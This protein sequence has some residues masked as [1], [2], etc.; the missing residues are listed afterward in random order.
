MR[1]DRCLHDVAQ[2]LQKSVHRPG[3]VVA[4]YGGE[5]FAVILPETT[6]EAA[7]EVAEKCR[8][9]VQELGIEHAANANFGVVTI[10][11][12][13]A[14]VVPEDALHYGDLIEMA[15]QA[16]YESKERGRNCVSLYRTKSS[17][18]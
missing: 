7:R 3:D 5:E 6:L 8:L 1:G 12:G 4:R 18:L 16:L 13:V 14:C 17:L 15:D 2:A 10:S 9:S 11:V